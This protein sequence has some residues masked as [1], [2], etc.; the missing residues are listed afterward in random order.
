[1][2]LAVFKQID[3]IKGI[4]SP[5][6]APQKFAAKM[7]WKNIAKSLKKPEK[8][9]TIKSKKSDFK[10]EHHYYVLSEYINDHE[11]SDALQK[12]YDAYFGAKLRQIVK[13]D[14]KTPEKGSKLARTKIFKTISEKISAIKDRWK[15]EIET[16]LRTK[17]QA[18]ILAQ[19]GL[20]FGVYKVNPE[21]SE[22]ELIYDN[23][24]FFSKDISNDVAKIV[25]DAKQFALKK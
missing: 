3:K 15:L 25:D 12:T 13:N 7:V 18:V 11:E 5:F 2:L 23:A 16:I 14:K 21:K 24:P 10:K 6:Q 20:Y 19:S 8:D 9:D 22:L 4:Y 17:T 1:M